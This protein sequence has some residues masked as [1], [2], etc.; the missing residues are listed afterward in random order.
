VR[1]TITMAL[2][3]VLYASSGTTA[4]A[5]C[6]GA[7]VGTFGA[8]GDGHSDDTTAIQ[9]AINAAGAAGGGSVVFNVARYFTTARF[10]YRRVW[11]CADP[12]KGHSMSLV[13]IRAPRLSR[14][15]YWLQIAV[16]PS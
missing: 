14:P 8:K 6:T 9:S 16:V 5:V 15:R 2:C 1:T 3:A 11:F 12:P 7:S 10:K 13:R 4:T